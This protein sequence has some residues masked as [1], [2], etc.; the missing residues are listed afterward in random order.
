MT[1]TKNIF[2]LTPENIIN[3]AA[4]VFKDLSLARN[5]GI[6]FI[7]LEQNFEDIVITLS[8]RQDKEHFR[9][10][11]HLYATTNQINRHIGTIYPLDEDN[12]LSRFLNERILAGRSDECLKK[13]AI[14]DED[15]ESLV[16]VSLRN[17]IYMKNLN[18]KFLSAHMKIQSRQRLL[19]MGVPLP[20]PG[21]THPFN[22]FG[23]ES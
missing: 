1:P 18:P 5:L 7:G 6:I 3:S 20:N 14:P 16:R 17:R 23:G 4:E 21:E 9:L 19:N 10:V 15:Q 2:F 11:Y 13:A 8:A 22:L 12:T